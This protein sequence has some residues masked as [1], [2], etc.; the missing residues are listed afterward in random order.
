M[1]LNFVHSPQTT[2]RSLQVNLCIV[3]R[4]TER[5]RKNKVTGKIE[6]IHHRLPEPPDLKKPWALTPT[7]QALQRHDDGEW[8]N[9]PFWSSWGLCIPFPLKQAAYLSQHVTP[10]PPQLREIC[11]CQ[12]PRSQLLQWF[13]IP[14]PTSPRETQRLKNLQLRTTY[15]V[16][17][18]GELGKLGSSSKR[19]LL[20]PGE[21]WRKLAENRGFQ[22]NTRTSNSRAEMNLEGECADPS[23][24]K[25]CSNIPL[26]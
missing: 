22:F 11:V 10:L 25:P 16:G 1:C 3:G 2:L 8:N 9:A 5:G 24:H 12:L 18:A 17:E 7:I 21:Y 6:K 15:H 26:E 4:N 19:G 14:G 13:V 23:M 20:M